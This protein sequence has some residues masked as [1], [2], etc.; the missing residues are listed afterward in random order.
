MTCSSNICWSCRHQARTT[1]SWR[2]LAV[3]RWCSSTG[4]PA[5]RY[6]KEGK[7]IESENA[8]YILTFSGAFQF[9]PTRDHLPLCMNIRNVTHS[10]DVLAYILSCR[11]NK[12]RLDALGGSTA[13]GAMIL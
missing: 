12:A 8:I 10:C 7:T 6:T 1:T 3:E 2:P 5:L 11:K 9:T 4:N 13:D